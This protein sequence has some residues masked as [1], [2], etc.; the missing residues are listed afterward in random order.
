MSEEVLGVMR[1]F[2]PAF[3]RQI[4]ETVYFTPDR[5]VVARTSGGK[6]GVL[7]GAVGGAIEGALQY[8]EAKKKGEQ[9]SQ[10]S[11]EDVLKADKNNY[12]IPNSE[13]T[14]VELKKFG[15]GTKL[16]IKTSQKHGKSMYGETNWYAAEGAWKDIGE[17]YENMLRPIFKDRLIV[18]K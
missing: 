18:K 12:A 13:I 11:L 8:E 14:E 10:L 7:L 1:V 16:N 3:M 2:R 9:Y 4:Y 5:T 15:K 6:G 17:K